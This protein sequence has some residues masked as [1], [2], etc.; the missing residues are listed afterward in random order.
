MTY[1][2]LLSLFLITA[3]MACNDK[4]AKIKLALK[5]ATEAL[6]I[7][8]IIGIGQIIPEKDIISL[9][10]PVNGIVQKLYLTENDSVNIGTII[11]ELEHELED[12]KINLIRNQI[13][14]Q[15]ALIKVDEASVSELHPKISNAKLETERLQ[16]L[17]QRGAET[18]Q[19]VDNAMTNLKSLMANQYK[20]EANVS[21]SKSKWLETKAALKTA[22]K[23]RNQKIIRSP[24]KGKILEL[25]TLPGGSVTIGQSLGQISPY[26]KIIAI[27]EID[28]ANADKISTGQKSWIR[29]V[30]SSDTLTT[31]TVYSTSS[32]LKKK[33]L[34]TD[35]SGE[36][37][38]RRVRTIKIMLDD[39]E[40]LLLN[41]RVECIVDISSN[42]K[43]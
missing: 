11:M 23:E 34:F 31:G 36:K 7:N 40:K 1:Q 5:S 6:S 20:A 9:S 37:E 35:Q 3:L 29:S 17:M 32:F 13:N 22:Q 41:A 8:Y 12:E 33:S 38:D 10:T 30:G 4:E 21:V 26:G 39:T 15:A 43:K 27:C 2:R 28:E 14:T 24:V 25:A 18:Q 16:N 42:P 19:I